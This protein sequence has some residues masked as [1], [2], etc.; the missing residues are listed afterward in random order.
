M[1]QLRVRTRTFEPGEQV[2]HGESTRLELVEIDYEERHLTLHITVTNRA[3]SALTV[4][5]KGLLLAYQELEFPVAQTP[6]I[7]LP[8]AILVQPQQTVELLLPFSP[9][10]PIHDRA[11]LQLRWLQRDGRDLEVLALP[12]PGRPQRP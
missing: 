2:A 9:G 3:E 12:V 7:N 4:Q 10:T 11:T 8:Q 5:R 1:H 6:R